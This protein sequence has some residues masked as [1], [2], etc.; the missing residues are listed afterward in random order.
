MNKDDNSERTILGLLRLMGWQTGRD[1]E[2]T[3]EEADLIFEIGANH[4]VTDEERD[5]LRERVLNRKFGTTPLRQVS[6]SGAEA[7]EQADERR[8][9]S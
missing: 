3:D 8:S 7:S 6:E 5:R 4:S 1:R 9:R 2:L